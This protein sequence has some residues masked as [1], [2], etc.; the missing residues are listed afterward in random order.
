MLLHYFEQDRKKI[1]PRI[2]CTIIMLCSNLNRTTWCLLCLLNKWRQM[3]QMS[4]NEPMKWEHNRP[5]PSLYNAQWRISSVSDVECENM[6]KQRLVLVCLHV[7][8]E[9]P[10]WAIR[11]NCSMCWCRGSHSS[12]GETRVQ[13]LDHLSL[14]VWSEGEHGNML[15]H[16]KVLSRCYDWVSHPLFL[17]PIKWKGICV[18]AF[19]C[20]LCWSIWSKRLYFFWM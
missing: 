11:P 20:A 14:W 16:W 10:L 6:Q 3:I 5:S 9:E 12:G 15:G 19:H 2:N 8:G 4:A 7:F 17:S 18:I 1:M 13:Q